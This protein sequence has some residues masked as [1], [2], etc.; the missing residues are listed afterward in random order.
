MPFMRIIFFLQYFSCLFILISFRYFSPKFI[1]FFQ[2]IVHFI[3]MFTTID[4][5]MCQ[6]VR[7]PTWPLRVAISP[8]RDHLTVDDPTVQGHYCHLIVQDLLSLPSYMLFLLLKC[9][10]RVVRLQRYLV[11]SNLRPGKLIMKGQQ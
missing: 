5:N 3:Q 10:L 2:K 4:I 8:L 6:S 9:L 1:F 11:C 7:Q